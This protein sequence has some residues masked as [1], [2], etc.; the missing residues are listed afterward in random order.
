MLV[1]DH[2][3]SSIQT[4]V[5]LSDDLHGLNHLLVH[6]APVSHSCQIRY[7]ETIA[8]PNTGHTSKVKTT[9]VLTILIWNVHMHGHV[10]VHRFDDRLL[11]VHDP[12]VGN[13]NCNDFGH[14]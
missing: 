13:F 3:Q 11:H 14:L 5:H 9:F 4:E 7:A 6:H 12:F 2:R 1:Y 8:P 10:L